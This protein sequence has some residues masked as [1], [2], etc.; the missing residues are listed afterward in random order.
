MSGSW[1]PNLLMVV[2]QTIALG[3]NEVGNLQF[4]KVCPS[5]LLVQQAG[6]DDLI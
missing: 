2:L 6:T 3:A 1:H 4:S 5:A